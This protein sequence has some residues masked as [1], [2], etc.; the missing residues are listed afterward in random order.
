MIPL[1]FG[2]SPRLGTFQPPCRGIDTDC[3]ANSTWANSSHYVPHPL[4]EGVFPFGVNVIDELEVPH[5]PPG[6]YVLGLRYDAE[7]T[8]QVWQQCADI[9]VS[10]AP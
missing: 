2:V 1:P 4:C 9:M 8:A 6:A 7:N 5:V 3:P 10:S